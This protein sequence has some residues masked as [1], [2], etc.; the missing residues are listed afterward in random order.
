MNLC[1]RLLLLALLLSPLHAANPE[2][3]E[4]VQSA[5]AAEQAHDTARAL[6]LF[7]AADAARP[8]NAFILQKISRQYSDSTIDTPDVAEKKRRIEQALAYAR[9]SHELE[10]GN[11]VYALSVA[12]CHGKLGLYSNTRARVENARLVKIHAE[13]ALE[14]DPAY[15]WACHVLGRWHY[16][17]AGLGLTQ[18]WLV[19]LVFGGLPEASPT[20]AVT[21]LQRAVTLA[22]TNPGHQIELGFAYLANGQPDLAQQ[23]WTAGLALPSLEKHDDEAKRRAREALEATRGQR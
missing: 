15:D 17:V 20:Q 18:R 1:Y 4:L 22:S 21:L 11:A 8:N 14:L 5:L 2:S 23:A 19:R 9:R 7:L 3:E 12:I 6:E 10:P 16:E 13:R